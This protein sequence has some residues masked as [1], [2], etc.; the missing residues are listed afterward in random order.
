[1]YHNYTI[2]IDECNETHTCRENSSC[3]NT[4]GSYDCVCDEGYKKIDNICQGKYFCFD[5]ALLLFVV[6]QIFSLAILLLQRSQ[7]TICHCVVDLYAI[8]MQ[9]VITLPICVCV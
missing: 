7:L 1:M 5:A 3:T 2:D 9:N 8:K 6:I 4:I